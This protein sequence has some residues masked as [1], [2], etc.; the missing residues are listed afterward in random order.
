MMTDINYMQLCVDKA[1]VSAKCSGNQVTVDI[2]NHYGDIE[3]ACYLYSNNKVISK[4][5]YKSNHYHQFTVSECTDLKCK[6]FFRS[7]DD[8]KIKQTK[9]YDVVNIYSEKKYEITGGL[10][11]INNSI[12]KA[13]KTSQCEI[14]SSKTNTIELYEAQGFKPRADCLPYPIELPISWLEDPFNDRNWMFQLHAWRMLDAYLLRA[15]PKDFEYIANIINDWVQFEKKNDSKW[16]WY[17]MSTG[18]RALKITLYLKLCYDKSITHNIEDIDYLLHAHFKHLSNPNEL[19]SGNHGLFQL[20]G[21]KSL[22]Y[23]VDGISSDS[24][25]MRALQA[26]ADKEMSKLITSQLGTKGVHTE[27]SPDYHFFAVKKIKRIVNSPWWTDLKQKNIQYLE[28]AEHAKPWLVFPDRRCVPIGDSSSGSVIKNLESLKNWPHMRCGN[29]ISARLDGYAVI[30]SDSSVSLKDSAFL[31]F[32]ASFHSQTHKHRDD[33]S[34]ILQEEGINLLIDSGKYGYQKGKYREYFT[35]TRAHNTIE[36]DGNNTARDQ[37]YAY[38]SALVGQPA[39]IDGFWCIK[40][41][42]NHIVN[43]YEHQR[44]IAY[45]P[46]EELF[47]IDK[48]KNNKKSVSKVRTIKQWWHF[49]PN[50]VVSK[51]NNKIKVYLDKREKIEITSEVSTNEYSFEIYRG[52]KDNNNLIGWMSKSYLNIEPTTSL[53]ISSKFDKEFVILSR[54]KLNS[55]LA[56]SVIKIK[57]GSV[58]SDLLELN[59]YISK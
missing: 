49:N 56:E 10:Y 52:F 51:E 13:I 15:Q 50:A 1:A 48:V 2:I 23:I 42:V 36:V 9:F 55:D 33:L 57:N 43:S 17:D 28:A 12:S 35:S 40:A 19:N 44:I 34:F 4:S 21:L 24:C 11:R 3:C 39:Y 30:R 26:Y 41:R 58:V 14:V 31:F 7:K 29:Y 46:G 32:Q 45:R 37:K 20:H 16:L 59:E 25:S 53:S 38:G 54:F 27:D 47:V 5:G 18:L 6:V 8:P 22:T